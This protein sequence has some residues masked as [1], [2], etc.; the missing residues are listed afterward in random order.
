ML[1]DRIAEN[2]VE[3]LFLKGEYPTCVADKTFIVVQRGNLRQV[4]N[5]EAGVTP[6]RGLKG[7]KEKICERYLLITRYP[8]IK[9][10]ATTIQAIEMINFFVSTVS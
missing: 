7:I 5:T 6:A 4:L 1:D 8:D 10:V 9:D 3:Y 2:P